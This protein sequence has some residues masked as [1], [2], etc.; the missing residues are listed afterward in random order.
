MMTLEVNLTQNQKRIGS[1]LFLERS[2]QQW[3]Q[4]IERENVLHEGNEDQE[5]IWLVHEIQER[6]VTTLLFPIY[7]PSASNWLA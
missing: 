1:F 7:W 2:W 3:Q 4:E 6:F 5:N